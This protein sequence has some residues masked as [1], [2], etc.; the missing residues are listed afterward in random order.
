M[1]FNLLTLLYSD[2]TENENGIDQMLE[3]IV[4]ILNAL[5]IFGLDG[6]EGIE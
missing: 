2:H 3:T 6:M 4:G 1:L 5:M